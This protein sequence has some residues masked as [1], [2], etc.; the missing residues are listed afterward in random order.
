MEGQGP[1]LTQCVIGPHKCTCQMHPNPSNGLG[2][3]HECDRQTDHATEKRVAIGVIACAAVI[4]THTSAHTTSQGSKNPG[5]FKKA[6]PSGFWG[7]YWVFGFNWVFGQAQ[8]IGKII[9]KLSNLK[10]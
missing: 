10:S 6:Q 4:T 3:V 9:Q 7:F 2:R 5:F 8:K 1:H